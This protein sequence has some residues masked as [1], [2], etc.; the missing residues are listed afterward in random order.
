MGKEPEHQ[1][2]AS[3]NLIKI[4]LNDKH[5]KLYIHAEE[6]SCVQLQLLHHFLSVTCAC[7]ACVVCMQAKTCNPGY[8]SE[9]QK[10]LIAIV[11]WTALI[12]HV[13]SYSY[14]CT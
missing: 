5:R 4:T 6:R 9:Y 7:F 8:L 3:C 1:P 2:Y 12:M 11:I 14:I 13:L 10:Q